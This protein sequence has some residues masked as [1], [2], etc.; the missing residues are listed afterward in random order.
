[1]LL[2]KMAT[3]PPWTPR[4]RLRF[5]LARHDG[6]G[7]GRSRLTNWTTR[8]PAYS[9]IH[10]I[11][12][13]HHLALDPE[14]RLDAGLTRRGRENESGRG[15]GNERCSMSNHP[16]SCHRGPGE[17]RLRTIFTTTKHQLVPVSSRSTASSTVAVLLPE[18]TVRPGYRP[19]RLPPTRRSTMKPIRGGKRK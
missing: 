11:V 15:K 5:P 8:N 12:N 18:S 13:T 4:P 6:V 2:S 14:R 10:P 1:M 7:V 16:K 17:R 9:T 3:L 19:A